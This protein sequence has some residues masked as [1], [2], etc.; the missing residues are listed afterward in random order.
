MRERRMR[1]VVNRD[2]KMDEYN[3]PDE[4]EVFARRLV[5]L[6]NSTRYFRNE[7]PRPP[8]WVP[9]ESGWKLA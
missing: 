9:W 8:H 1:V 7:L 6:E 3:H 2:L 4:L 5:S